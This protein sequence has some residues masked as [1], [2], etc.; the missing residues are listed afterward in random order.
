MRSVQYSLLA[1][2]LFTCGCVDSKNPLS[3]PDGAKVDD[4]LVGTWRFTSAKETSLLQVTRAGD[5]FPKGMLRLV[6]VDE[7]GKKTSPS[8]QF[9]AFCTTLNHKTYLNLI[10]DE[11]TIAAL[12]KKGWKSTAV[13]GYCIMKYE[14]AGDEL[15]LWMMDDGAKEKAI[16]SGKV[17]GKITKATR[18]SSLAASCFTDSSDKVAECVEESSESLFVPYPSLDVHCKRVVI[19]KN[20]PKQ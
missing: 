19:P 14:V 8:E 1:A 6:S 15:K 16:K 7:S 13:D 17:K 10:E 9:L 5:K 2:C 3:S 11:E 12:D 20:S 18:F 4:Q